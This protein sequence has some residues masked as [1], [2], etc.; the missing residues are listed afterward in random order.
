MGGA[1]HVTRLERKVDMARSIRM[2]LLAGASLLIS[3]LAICLAAAVPAYALT[4][5]KVTLNEET[6]G[7]PTRFTFVAGTDD[8]ATISSVE[9]EFPEGFDLEDSRTRIVLLEGLKRIP[10]DPAVSV[11]GTKLSLGFDPPIPPTSTLRVEVYDVLTTSRGGKFELGVTYSAET[12]GDAGAVTEERSAEGVGFS[13]AT[14]P[15]G[16]QLARWLDRQEWVESFNSVKAL[17]MFF[18]PQI[19]A[20]AVPLLF[21]GWLMSIGLVA[22]AFPLAIFMGLTLAFMRMSKVVVLRWIA[23]IYINIIRGTPLFLQIF[24]AFIGLRIA[25]IRAPDFATGV[26]VLALNSAAYLA[27]IFR[28]GIQSIHRG[29]FEAA[30]SLGMN[31]WKAMA[32]VIIPQT[33]KRVLPTM[34]SE[35]ILLF[36]DTALLAAVGLFELMMKAQNLSSRTGNLTSFMVA[37]VYYLIVT[38]PLINWVGHLEARLAISEQGKTPDSPK[39][40]GG[41]FWRPASAGPIADFEASAE[42]HQSR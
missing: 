16:E 24:V 22:L 9:F 38:I 6:G 3:A 36:K 26:L 23:G 33:V 39:R 28:A 40:R 8:D 27:E 19:I 42:V 1:S 13:F 4:D 30:S 41:L 34:T 10:V 20:I 35:F 37:A 14:A 15:A 2:K 21:T 5:P 32:N 17:G 18:K 31:Y 12:T 29:Q 11:K 7:Q 25:G